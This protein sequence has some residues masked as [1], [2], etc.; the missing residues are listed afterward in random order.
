M[1]KGAS[2]NTRIHIKRFEHS[3][4]ENSGHFILDTLQLITLRKLLTK[5]VSWSIILAKQLSPRGNWKDK[6]KDDESCP[7]GS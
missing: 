7:S 1:S 3:R 5:A 6:V 4:Q 2:G